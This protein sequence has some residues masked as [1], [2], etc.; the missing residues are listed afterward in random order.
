MCQEN[1]VLYTSSIDYQFKNSIIAIIF[2][3]VERISTQG[4]IY[5]G[6]TCKT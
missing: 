3:R 5:V 4:V 2:N 6:T 1:Y